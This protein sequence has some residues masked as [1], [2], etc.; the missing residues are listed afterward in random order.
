MY[1]IPCCSEVGEREGGRSWDGEKERNEEGRR[2][3][4]ERKDEVGRK[5]GRKD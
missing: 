2:R 3:D 1:S 4:G 5:E